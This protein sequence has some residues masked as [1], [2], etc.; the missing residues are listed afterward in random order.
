LPFE[1]STAPALVWAVPLSTGT[2]FSTLG[3]S[4]KGTRKNAVVLS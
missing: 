2:P 4:A 3:W 1:V